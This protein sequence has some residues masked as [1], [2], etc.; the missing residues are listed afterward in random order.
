MSTVRSGGDD[1]KSLASI[2]F[3]I[4]DYLDVAVCVNTQQN[5][6][7]N[8]MNNNNQQQKTYNQPQNRQHQQNFNQPH[9]L[10]NQFANQQR[11]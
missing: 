3:E 5:K 8:V 2:N 7:F 9:N 6:H 10:S 1:E 11:F 4:G